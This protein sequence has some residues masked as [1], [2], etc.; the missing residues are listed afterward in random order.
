MYKYRTMV[1]LAHFAD[2]ILHVNRLKLITK[3]VVL[4]MCLDLPPVQP[5]G[6]WKEWFPEAL[7]GAFYLQQSAAKRALLSN[8][9]TAK[10]VSSI[11]H[12]RLI[13]GQHPPSPPLVL[14]TSSSSPKPDQAPVH[15]LWR[16]RHWLPQTRRP[17]TA[18]CCR[19]CR[20]YH[21][22]CPF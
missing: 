9:N 21:L 15:S 3:K 4:H 12:N 18:W 13:T 16:G 14:V 5:D 7:S 10:Q 19:L 1:K 11:F 20:T 6:H 8:R 2:K 17:S 22:L